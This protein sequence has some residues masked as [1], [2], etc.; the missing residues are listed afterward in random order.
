MAGRRTNLALIPLLAGAVASG[1]AMYAIGSGWNAWPTLIHGAIG[2]AVVMASPWK[3]AVTRRGVRRHGVAESAPSLLLALA[4]VTALATGF[5]H[6]AGARDLGL[7]LVMQLHVGAAVVAVPL[8]GWHVLSRPV[9]PRR[10]DLDRRALVWGGIATGGAAALTVA[11]PHAGGRPTRSLEVASMPVTQWFDDDVQHI[12]AAEWRLR[13]D[14][15]PMALDDWAQ[16][17]LTAVLDC[18]GGWYAERRWSGVRLDRLVGDRR[19]RSILVRSAT[20]YT[21]R[22]PMSDAPRLL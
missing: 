14:G 18:T 22:F 6:R 20:G 1:L 8:A 17:E 7:L 4:V 2:I 16:D 3:S 19:G 15:R 5:A 9:R 11:L 10:T 21:R 12:D 13:V